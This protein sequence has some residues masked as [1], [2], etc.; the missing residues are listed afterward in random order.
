MH[1]TGI[2]AN[3]SVADL[4]EARDFYVDFLGLSVEGF[5]LG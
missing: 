3:L 1:A 4:A 5:N 2:T